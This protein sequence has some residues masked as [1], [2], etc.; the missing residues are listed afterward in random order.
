[1]WI[2]VKTLP[3]TLIFNIFVKK[4]EFNVEDVAN[5]LDIKIFNRDFSM[6]EKLQLDSSVEI[7][8]KGEYDRIRLRAK[9]SFDIKQ[10]EF[11]EFLKK[12]YNSFKQV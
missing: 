1:M 3:S 10:T 4:Q 6:S 9:E 11:L 12:C 2:S 7:T 5:S 8:N